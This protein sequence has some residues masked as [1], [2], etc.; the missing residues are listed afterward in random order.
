MHCKVSSAW[1]PKISRSPREAT[2][3]SW[4]L[5]PSGTSSGGSRQ[6]TGR[7]EPGHQRDLL[8][9]A[10][11]TISAASARLYDRCLSMK[12]GTARPEAPKTSSTS[13]KNLPRG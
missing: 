13:R 5:R 8:A 4:N 10:A 9:D 7:L 6:V 3:T 2:S 11:L 1:K 12:T